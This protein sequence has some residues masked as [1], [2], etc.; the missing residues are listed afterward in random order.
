MSTLKQAPVKALPF[1]KQRGFR[2][3]LNQRID[4][5]MSENKLPARDVPAMY[6]KTAVVL[7]WWIVTYTLLLLGGFSWPITAVLCLSL[8]FAIAGVGFNVMHDAIHGGYSN[9]PWMNKLMGFTVE[10]LGASSFVWR[11]KHNVW[12]H[13]YTNIS[14]LD[15]DLESNGLLRLSPHEDWKPGFQFQ[16]WYMP[17]VY[18]L[19]SFSF[20]IRDFRVFFTGKSDE[21]HV[22]PK[23]STNDRGLFLLGKTLYFTLMIGIPLL[24]FPWWQVLVQWFAIMFVVGVTLAAIFQLAHVMEPATFPE[25]VGDPLHIENEWAIHEVETTVNF[26]PRNALVNWY[27][28][29][30]NYQIEHHLFPHICHV[31][32]PKLSP[33]VRATCAEF[34]VAYNSY[35]TWLGALWGHIKALEGLGRRPA[36]ATVVPRVA[37]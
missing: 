25:P 17:F 16:Q 10:L 21:H 34:D 4:A 23:M 33:I 12:H 31:H 13:T 7:A 3:L 26:A 15:E 14:G 36:S 24:V 28:G 29:G 1:T 32:Y 30:L 22:F 2:K 5:Y 6:L 20:I 37:K 19:T 11:Q 8:S 35:D 9:K 27:S 18:G